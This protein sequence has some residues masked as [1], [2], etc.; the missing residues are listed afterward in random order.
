M[1]FAILIFVCG[2]VSIVLGTRLLDQGRHGLSS[3]YI[4]ANCSA[5]TNA[6]KNAVYCVSRK[7][8]VKITCCDY[9]VAIFPAPQSFTEWTAR[10]SFNASIQKRACVTA[11]PCAT[12][13]RSLSLDYKSGPTLFPC[14]FNPEK[15]KSRSLDN[16]YCLVPSIDPDYFGR[17]AVVTD[18]E[19]SLLAVADQSRQQNR[20]HFL[21]LILVG[22]CGLVLGGIAGVS[23]F[24]L[25]FW[26]QSSAAVARKKPR[27]ARPLC[28]LQSSASPPPLLPPQPGRA[29]YAKEE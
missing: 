9:P 11:D 5:M 10:S 17:C 6:G 27:L 29:G 24:F 23:L 15:I 7:C 3:G 25:E 2:I 4:D 20:P 28:S 19:F 12:F 1:G 14:K 8:S 16:N 18:R 26:R 22:A 13:R 21:A